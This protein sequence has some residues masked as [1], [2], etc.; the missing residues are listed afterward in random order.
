MAGPL[1]PVSPFDV[2]ASEYF[3]LPSSMDNEGPKGK[4]VYPNFVQFRIEAMRVLVVYRVL[5]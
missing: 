1:V 4:R 3:C 5:L 2:S